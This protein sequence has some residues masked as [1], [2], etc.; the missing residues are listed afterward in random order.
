MIGFEARPD[1]SLVLHEK[2]H[3]RKSF[4][5]V[6]FF[7]P[8]KTRSKCIGGVKQPLAFQ[9]RV[10]IFLSGVS[11]AV[12]ACRSLRVDVNKLDETAPPQRYRADLFGS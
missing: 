8:F 10:D 2:K 12:S 9:C 3:L 7:S 5:P 6:F 1:L 4:I 11:A